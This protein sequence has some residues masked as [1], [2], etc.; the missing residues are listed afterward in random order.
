ME[1][2]VN[3]EDIFLNS[4]NSLKCSYEKAKD[5]LIDWLVYTQGFPIDGYVVRNIMLY[6][7]SYDR[8]EVFLNH[9][10]EVFGNNSEYLRQCLVD[11]IDH[12]KDNTPLPNFCEY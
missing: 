4:N 7:N 2:S 12:F 1:L 3:S 6:L 8:I 5:L 9:Y 11:I 10:I